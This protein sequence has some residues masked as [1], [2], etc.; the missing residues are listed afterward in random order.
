MMALTQTIYGHEFLAVRWVLLGALIITSATDLIVVAQRKGFVMRGGSGHLLLIYLLMTFGT[1][2]YA[3][4]WLFSVMRWAS[5]AVMLL[6]FMLLLPQIIILKQ[7]PKLLV[8]LKYLLCAMLVISWIFPAPNAIV[9]NKH[10][11]Q[12]AMGNANTMGHIA[13]MTTILFLQDFITGKTPRMRFLPAVI[14]VA[15]SMTIWYSGA[16]S[17]MIAL[18][19]GTLLY[20]YFYQKKI[21]GLVIIGLLVGSL[22]MIAFP[23]VPQAI[24][25]FT[26]KSA[27]HKAGVQVNPLQSRT[28]IWSAAYKGFKERPIFGWGFGAD[29]KIKKQWEIKLTAIGAVERDAVNDFLFMMEGCGIVGLVAYFLLIYLVIKQRPGRD[30]IDSNRNF[31]EGRKMRSAILELKHAH[32]ALFILPACLL[33]LNQFDNSALSAGN[34]ISV[35]LWFSAGC[36]AILRDEMFLSR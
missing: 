26:L 22:A 33:V 5:H 13:F 23:N 29:R 34:F 35:T 7:I 21:K 14:T 31:D 17:S 9:M 24:M 30:S 28:P 4:N 19:V 16:R 18:A 2:I 25:Q 3:E 12:G 36:A 1:V 27:R 11:Y 15:G 8:Y 10:L 6:I 20:F 32:I